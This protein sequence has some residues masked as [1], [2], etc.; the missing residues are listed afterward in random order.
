MPAF[1]RAWL[2]EP[3]DMTLDEYRSMLAGVVLRMHAG[4]TT[5]DQI[6][7]FRRLAPPVELL[8]PTLTSEAAP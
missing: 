7:V 3:A 6:G 2:A 8:R 5:S 1:E 4:A